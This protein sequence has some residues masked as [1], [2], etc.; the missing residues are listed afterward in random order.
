VPLPSSIVEA[1]FRSRTHAID[2]RRL[3]AFAACVG[4]ARPELIDTARPGGVVAHPLF[5]VVYEWRSMLDIAG[6]LRE[7]GMTWD[8]ALVAT[9]L[10]YD[11]RWFATV[12][13]G[14]QV[15]VS[16]DVDEAR[17]TP[18]GATLTIVTTAV[19][20]AG[21]PVSR[22]RAH[23]LFPESKLEGEPRTR[24]GVAPS[25][26]PPARLAT[27]DG[28]APVVDLRAAWSNPDAVIRRGRRRVGTPAAHVFSE[29][30]GIW[31]PVYTDKAVALRHGRAFLALPPAGTLAM[32]VGGVLQLGT[33]D[34]SWVRRISAE[35]AAPVPVPST[36]EIEAEVPH[37]P[38]AEAPL[39]FRASLEDGTPVVAA[40][41]LVAEPSDADVEA[42]RARTRVQRRRFVG[43][44]ARRTPP[45]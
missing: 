34:P 8:E 11:V 27:G 26:D 29:C 36:L 15:E 12:R 31:N 35:F 20:G 21:N 23:V 42:A 14:A 24:A 33:A 25:A 38:S 3:M 7:R 4:D 39:R 41:M 19:D 10:D 16:V 32:T 18:D 28:H 17:S 6:E 5:P 37:R 9:P 45:A 22:S 13:A 2:E 1:T 40:G 30:S 44:P 43:A